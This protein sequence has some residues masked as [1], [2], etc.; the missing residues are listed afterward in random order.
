M[1]VMV[2]IAAWAG[3]APL[4]L[5]LAPHS[6]AAAVGI[7]AGTAAAAEVVA[8]GTAAALASPVVQL[9]ELH[10]DPLGVSASRWGGGN[11][12][13]TIERRA[14]AASVQRVRGNAMLCVHLVVLQWA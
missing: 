5:A 2:A 8:A 14:E 11:A 4:A 9:L 12:S 1:H 3:A 10:H 13:A 7:A 6:L